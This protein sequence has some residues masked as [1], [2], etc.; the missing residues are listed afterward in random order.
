MAQLSTFIRTCPTCTMS[1][2]TSLKT[3]YA[4]PG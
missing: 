2:V 1:T 4:Y 3:R